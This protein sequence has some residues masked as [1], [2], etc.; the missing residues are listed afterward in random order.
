MLLFLITIAVVR[1]SHAIFAMNGWF[2]RFLSISVTVSIFPPDLL[3]NYYY[4]RAI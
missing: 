3:S 1:S 2:Y 4:L